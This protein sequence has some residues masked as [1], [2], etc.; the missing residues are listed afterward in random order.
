[1][2]AYKYKIKICESTMDYVHGMFQ[3]IDEYY[4]PSPVNLC[5]NYKAVFIADE[6]TAEARRDEATDTE[7]IEVGD[8]GMEGRLIILA[9]HIAAMKAGEEE[10]RKILQLT[11]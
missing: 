1:M 2:K 9:T 3:N 10:M 5:F 11:E 7:E 6:E 8:E 4:F